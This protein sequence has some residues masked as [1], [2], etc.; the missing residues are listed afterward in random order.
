M[1]INKEKYLQTLKEKKKSAPNSEKAYWLGE[2]S[3]LVDRPFKQVAGLVGWLPTH[4][5]KEMFED[6]RG[7][8][9]K[10]WWL[11]KKILGKEK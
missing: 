11:R 7:D 2:T 10:W 9:K 3:K 1:E 5:I 8:A 4:W 6:A